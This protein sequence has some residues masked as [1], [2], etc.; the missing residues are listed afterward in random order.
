LEKAAEWRLFSTVEE[1]SHGRGVA[2]KLIFDKKEILTFARNWRWKWTYLATLLWQQDSW[3]KTS[4]EKLCAST[5]LFQSLV[6]SWQ[7]KQLT[8]DLFPENN[9]IIFSSI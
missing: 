7:K 4:W 9:F 3:L 8:V 5:T 6:G 2:A 1:H